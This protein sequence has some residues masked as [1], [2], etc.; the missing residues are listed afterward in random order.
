MNLIMNTR[1]IVTKT[2]SDGETSF[3]SISEFS[4]GFLPLAKEVVQ[5]IIHETKFRNATT[6]RLV[7]IELIDL[8]TINNVYTLTLKAVIRKIVKL[9]KQFTELLYYDKK[10][11]CFTKF[12]FQ[13]KTVY[14]S[15]G[16]S[17]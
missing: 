15:N 12:Y 7:A 17:F 8:W 13:E 11:N 2:F 5:R 4:N 14:G 3:S 16:I 10:T 6:A 9:V 1:R